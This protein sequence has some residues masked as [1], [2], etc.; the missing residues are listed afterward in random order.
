MGK[1]AFLKNVIYES[2]NIP[3]SL[4]IAD[5]L[6]YASTTIF[7]LILFIVYTP[8]MLLLSILA[9]LFVII[10]LSYIVT[11]HLLRSMRKPI[12]L[13]TFVNTDIPQ[14]LSSFLNHTASTS[15]SPSTPASNCETTNTFM[16]TDIPKSL[17]KT[18]HS[19][20]NHTA[21][22]STPASNCETTKDV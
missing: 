10:I 17:P 11:N 8:R 12:N 22:S 21:K 9:I 4:T 7:I 13:N 3:I 5:L 14:S 18:L 1:T 19:F 2:M 16:N 20:L 6:F 15:T